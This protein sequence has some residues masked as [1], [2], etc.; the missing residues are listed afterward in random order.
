M[1]EI[2]SYEMYRLLPSDKTNRIL[3]H[4]ILLGI[5]RGRLYQINNEKKKNLPLSFIISRTLNADIR[6]CRYF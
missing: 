3:H 5:Y 1:F 2:S 6:H 4:S